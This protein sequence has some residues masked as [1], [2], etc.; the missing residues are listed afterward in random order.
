MDGWNIILPF[1]T[2][3]IFRGDLLYIVLGRVSVYVIQWSLYG[4]Q[5]PGPKQVEL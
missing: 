3:P 2:W 4:L 5:R 1:G